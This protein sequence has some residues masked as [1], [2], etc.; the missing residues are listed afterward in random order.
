MAKKKTELPV[1]D[2]KVALLTKKLLRD[3]NSEN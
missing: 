1:T 2:K 3:L